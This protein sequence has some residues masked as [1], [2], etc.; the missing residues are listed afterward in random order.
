MCKQLLSLCEQQTWAC[1]LLMT[2]V[3]MREF[4]V[5]VCVTAECL[6]MTWTVNTVQSS[7]PSLRLW[8]TDSREIRAGSQKTLRCGGRRRG[9][10][11]GLSLTHIHTSPVELCFMACEGSVKCSLI[12][13]VSTVLTGAEL[14]SVTQTLMA[15][16]MRTDTTWIAEYA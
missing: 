3:G 16:E 15:Q 6:L 7:S 2:P 11:S 13:A 8:V 5:C 4:C 1:C 9:R 10:Q 14:D 12:T